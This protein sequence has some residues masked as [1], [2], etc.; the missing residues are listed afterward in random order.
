[1]CRRAIELKAARHPGQYQHPLPHADSSGVVGTDETIHGSKIDPLSGKRNEPVDKSPG[2][3][4]EV[5]DTARI[6]PMGEV[7]EE[8]P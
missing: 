5:V 4:D 1:M 8:M 3:S 7:R 6:Q 2:L